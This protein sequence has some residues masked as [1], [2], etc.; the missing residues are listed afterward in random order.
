MPRGL[1]G[2]AAT[3]SSRSR[4]KDVETAS[5]RRASSS[6]TGGRP[7]EGMAG[8]YRPGCSRGSKIKM[9]LILIVA[10]TCED[11]ARCPSP[12]SP[13]RWS[14][15]TTSRRASA[16]SSSTSSGSSRASRPTASRSWRRCGPAGAT[17]TRRSPIPSSGGPSSSSGRPTTSSGG[18]SRLAADHRADVV[19]F[20]HGF[21]LRGSRPGSRRAASRR[22]PSPTGPRRGSRGRPGSPRRNAGAARLP[23]GHLGQRAHRRSDARRARRA[24]AAHRPLSRRGRVA[25]HSYRRRGPRSRTLRRARSTARRV[26]VPAGAA[27][28]A[29]RAHRGDALRQGPHP[30]RGPPAG[31]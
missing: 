30:R 5:R 15:R 24:A 4:A 28:G 29:G 7:G 27:Q 22:S 31:G 20:G 3:P 10:P 6:V 18:S 12:M 13:E 14:S 2:R 26:R 16:A 21:P 11:V 17:T 8:W 25:V 19:L 1:P 23:R 9:S